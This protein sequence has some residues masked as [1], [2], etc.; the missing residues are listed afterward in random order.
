MKS[1][2]DFLCVCLT[3]SVRVPSPMPDRSTRTREHMVRI[4]ILYIRNPAPT[5]GP[6]LFVSCTVEHI[7][8]EAHRGVSIE[9]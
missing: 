8:T 3:L 1:L 9:Q 6:N 5:L 7:E 2:A 4:N